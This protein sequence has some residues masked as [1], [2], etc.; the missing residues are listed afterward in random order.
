M[1]KIKL[2]NTNAKNLT[3]QY[4]ELVKAYQDDT[5][6]MSEMQK[7]MQKI[8]MYKDTINKQE[9]VIDK[10]EKLLKKQI[11][12][13][14][15]LKESLIEI[16]RLKTDN[17]QLQNEIKKMVKKKSTSDYNSTNNN[18]F[19]DNDKYQNEIFRLENIIKDMQIKS[20]NNENNNNFN[21]SNRKNFP[22][23]DSVELEIKYN[24]SVEKINILENEIDNI[25]RNF[26]DEVTKLRLRLSEK[27]SILQS[28]KYNY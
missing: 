20:L 22:D 3:Q 6:K 9:E 16:D 12:D 8:D 13:S 5:K 27:D 4:N 23:K 15:K 7:N 24:K 10:Y 26:A 14:N 17:F 1:K 18:I 28:M 11:D 21:K 19:S 25:T 2:D